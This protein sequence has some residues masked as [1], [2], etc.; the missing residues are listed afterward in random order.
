MPHA[1][2]L[3]SKSLRN[4]SLHL[5]CPHP[6]GTADN[7]PSCFH[8]END[9][10]SENEQLLSRSM[11]SDEEP[12]ADKQGS[13]ELCLLSLV[14]LAREKSATPTKS[15]GVRLW[16]PVHTPYDLLVQQGNAPKDVTSLL[17]KFCS[18]V[19]WYFHKPEP[20]NLDGVTGL[21]QDILKMQTLFLSLYSF[22]EKMKNNKQRQ[23]F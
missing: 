7:P 12:A 14:H 9:A 15:A 2:E 23:K 22:I 21:K 6:W 19:W 11:D 20:G 1:H 8:S 16:W 18:V 3:P 13:P 4:W 17:H 10:S 5:D